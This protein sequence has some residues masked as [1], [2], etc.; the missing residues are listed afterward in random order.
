MNRPGLADGPITWIHLATLVLSIGAGAWFSCWA[1]LFTR[2]MGLSAGEFAIGV[3]IAGLIGLVIGSP[4]GYLADRVGTR[5]VLVWLGVIQGLATLSYVLVAEFWSFFL[6]TCVAVT[7]QRLAPAI[8]VAVISGLTTGEARLRS[9]ATNRVVL[10]VGIAVGSGIGALVLYLDSRA[11]Y[12]SLIVLYG[13]ANMA[14]ALVTLRVPH[15]SS[16]ADR[17]DKRRMLALRDRP[18]LVIT[19]LNGVLALN[20]GMLGTGLPLWITAH[21]DAPLWMVGVVTAFNA[22]AIM[23]FQKKVSKG[24]DTI[25]GAARQAVY[26]GAALA[27]S[28]VL[29]AATY[30]GSGLL[31]ICLLLAAA[32][33]H[34]VGELLF[35]ASGWG[36]SVALTPQEAHGEYQATFA[37]GPAAALMLA[38][39]VLTALVVEWGVMGWFALGVLFLLASVPVVPVSRWATRTGPRK[40]MVV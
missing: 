34:V 23:L 1:I 12:V 16:L 37:T 11:A 14:S 27:V 25:P 32:A 2:S 33:A 5:E 8:R 36:L 20:W 29:F 7:A 30:H 40:E 6:V 28:C 38:P 13:I 9:I 26:C 4:L 15:V 39:A 10:H 35:S 31:V 17:K 3:T 21:T 22:V 24:S 18:F 19:L